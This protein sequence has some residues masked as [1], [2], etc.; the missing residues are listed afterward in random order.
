MKSQ[1]PFRLPHL[2]DMPI[3]DL[4]RGANHA[5]HIPI[6]LAQPFLSHLPG[7]VRDTLS[8]FG[9]LAESIY[10]DSL[11]FWLPTT[12]E[13]NQATAFLNDAKRTDLAA[14]GRVVAWAL[15]IALVHQDKTQSFFISETVVTLALS[16]SLTKTASGPTPAERAAEAMFALISLGLGPH[17][18]RFTPPQMTPE[19]TNQ[20]RIAAFSAAL[21]LL[22]ARSSNLDDEIR[23]LNYAITITDI[24]A[25]DIKDSSINVGQIA[26]MLRHHAEMI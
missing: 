13:F 6:A 26:T 17:K 11:I 23:I 9:Q 14:T 12:L 7:P 20:L 16:A 15:E 4:M 18:Q 19:R 21:F 22:A 1:A 3:R 10:N 24:I 5:A 8:Q 2:E 25:L